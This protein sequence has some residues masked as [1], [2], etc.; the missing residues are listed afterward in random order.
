VLTEDTKK[1]HRRQHAGCLQSLQRGKMGAI[2]LITFL[3]QNQPK[4]IRVLGN[5]IGSENR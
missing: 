2:T 4:K 5:K 3:H 1:Y